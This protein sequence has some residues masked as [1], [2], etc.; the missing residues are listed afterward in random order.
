MN[1][2][3]DSLSKAIKEGYDNISE[4]A[5]EVTKIGRIKLEMV[6]TKRD[7]EKIFVELGGRFYQSYDSSSKSKMFKDVDVQ[8]LVEKVRIKEEKLQELKKR[9]EVLKKEE[10]VDLD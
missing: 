9:L 3:F 8:E 1:K 10:G 4:K 2:F 7:I 5:E 6:A